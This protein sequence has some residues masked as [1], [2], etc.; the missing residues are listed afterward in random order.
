[1]SNSLTAFSDQL[2][3][4]VEQTGRSVVAVRAHGRF[5]S[6]GVHWSP[7]VIVTASHTIRYDQDIRVVTPQGVVLPAELAGR[8]PGTDIA[9][10]RVPGF[11]GPAMSYGPEVNWKPGTIVV[12]VGRFKDAASAAMGLLSSVS[13]PSDTWRGGK[14]NSVLRLDI[15]L[16][17]GGAGGAVVDA[18]G[19]LIGVA[20]PALSRFSVFA[21]P[22]ATVA[23][24]AEKL[25]KHGRMPRGYLGVSLQS[26]AIME[27]LRAKLN[28]EA[29][30]GVIAI[31]V[32]PEGPAGK[33]GMTM[34]DV[35][36][37][38]GGKA[39]TDPEAVHA[40]LDADSIGQKMG[41]R[42]LRGGNCVDLEI[43]IGERPS[44]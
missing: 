42:I 30:T 8:D 34:G 31:S 40:V 29:T 27:Q 2:V 20:T 12:S 4:I 16:P 38:L 1:V 35:L 24:V 13:G 33:A 44:K 25:L 28:L 36:L 17:A 21:V 19:K 10:L 41:A 22:V 3:S 26:V 7:G 14:L 15:G 6:S 18:N 39:T 37:D 23:P 11:D 9:V 43:T 32:D 5:N